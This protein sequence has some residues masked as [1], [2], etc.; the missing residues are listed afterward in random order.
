[1]Q[2]ERISATHGRSGSHSMKRAFGSIDVLGACSACLF[3]LAL[4]VSGTASGRDATR[5]ART[6][7]SRSSRGVRAS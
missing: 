4:T 2:A 6:R 1:V 7:R 3:R 5:L